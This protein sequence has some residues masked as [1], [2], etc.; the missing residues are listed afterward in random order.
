[1]TFFSNLCIHFLN[2]KPKINQII[3]GWAT[4][5]CQIGYC[6]SPTCTAL[7]NTALLYMQWGNIIYD[8]V[9]LFY[10]CTKVPSFSKYISTTFIVL[11]PVWIWMNFVS[12]NMR[13]KSRHK[14]IIRMLLQKRISPH[15]A[16]CSNLSCVRPVFMTFH[17]L[18]LNETSSAR[19]I[20]RV[21]KVKACCWRTGCTKCTTA[22]PSK[23]VN[24]YIRNRNECASNR[25]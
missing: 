24:S 13:I 9:L 14:K 2:V 8:E 25:H 17:S 10:N 11:W 18:S 22:C 5:F 4:F 1:M 3:H 15:C 16:H 6:A 7:N 21:A 23:V 20:S 19:Q 12:T